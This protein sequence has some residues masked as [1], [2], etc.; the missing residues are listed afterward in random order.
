MSIPWKIVSTG[1]ERNF[2]EYGGIFLMKMTNIREKD[3][4]NV[5]YMSC[6][7]DTRLVWSLFH[8][9]GKG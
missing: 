9:L 7:E 8:W 4:Y 3:S 1:D 2:S 5:N 6:S